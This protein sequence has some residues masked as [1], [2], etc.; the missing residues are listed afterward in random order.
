[1]RLIALIIAL[2]L[3]VALVATQ[4]FLPGYLEHRIEHRLTEN[5]GRAS[6]TL[7]ALPALR[8]VAG[9]GDRL[10]ITGRG[11]DI[12]LEPS[13]L[14]SRSL[15][16]LDGFDEVELRLRGVRVQPFEVRRFELVRPADADTYD[17]QL[18]AVTTPLGLL[19]YGSERL[20]GLLA[21]LVGGTASALLRDRGRIPIDFV[22][23]VESADGR[24]RV[25]GAKGTVAGIEAGL[26]VQLLSGALLSRV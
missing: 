4:L 1:L 26:L 12:D 22:A 9:D 3:L 24:P 23:R 10:A 19:T 16:E 17:L 25:V 2:S 13:D 14:R 11:L 6:V 15:Q 18:S 20:P 8:L 21:V 7:E 5:G